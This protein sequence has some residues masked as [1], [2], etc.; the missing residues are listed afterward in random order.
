MAHSEADLKKLR[1]VAISAAG[2][3]GGYRSPDRDDFAA[4]ALLEIVP[5]L[6]TEITYDD[7]VYHVRRKA[8]N[9]RKRNQRRAERRT[10][11]SVEDPEVM[12]RSSEYPQPE[13]II[14]QRDYNEAMIKQV[15][16]V[17]KEAYDQLKERERFLMVTKK[18]LD[19]FGFTCPAPVG[20]YE[21]APETERKAAARAKEKFDGLVEKAIERHRQQ[22]SKF[23]RPF[24]D[25]LYRRVRG[26]T[27]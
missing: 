8:E 17:Y 16:M 14:E 18:G 3:F 10:T 4:A 27:G 21:L 12:L 5:L 6:G 25:D 22:A 13:A 19:A 20:V 15:R 2:G 9:A 23:D 1:R 24:W 11:F 26:V 7:L